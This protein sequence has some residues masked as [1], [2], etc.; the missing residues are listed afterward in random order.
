MQV[1]FASFARFL[2]QGDAPLLS[3]E[4]VMLSWKFFWTPLPSS[5]LLSAKVL[6]MKGLVSEL[7]AAP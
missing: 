2:S 5:P 4:E 7:S 3:M 1:S 6:L